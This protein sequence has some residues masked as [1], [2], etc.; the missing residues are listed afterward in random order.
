MTNFFKRSITG[1]LLAGMI[2]SMV[3]CGSTKT[4]TTTTSASTAAAAESTNTSAPVKEPVTLTLFGSETEK[5]FPTG[6]QTDAVAMDIKNKLG[7]TIDIVEQS[8]TPEKA[9]VLVASGDIPDMVQLIRANMEPLIT[10]K[11]LLPLD[12]LLKTNGPDIMKNTALAVAYSKKYMSLGQDKVY[13]LSSQV[14]PSGQIGNAIAPYIRWDYY[15]ELGYPAV[16]SYDDLLNVVDQMVKKHPTNENN[17]KQFGFSMWFD[18][19]TFA[20]GMLTGYQTAVQQI[21]PGLGIDQINKTEFSWIND[22]DAF[23]WKG[24][25][26]WNKANRMGLLDPDALTQSYDQALQKAGANRVICSIAKWVQGS[27]NKD[28]AKAGFP[29]RGI[30][31]LPP[32]TGTDGYMGGSKMMIGNVDRSWAISAECKYPDRAMDLLNYMFSEEGALT[33]YN[34]TKGENWT[35]NNGKYEM[36]QKFTDAIKNDSNYTLTSGA[37]KYNTWPGLGPTYQLASKQT[38][39][40]LKDK[41][42]LPATYTQ[43]DKD[44][45]KYYGIDTVEDIV[46]KFAK[47]PITDTYVDQ[48]TTKTPPTDINAGAQK[49][50]AYYIK[51]LPKMVLAKSDDQLNTMIAKFRADLKEMNVDA[52]QK[53][54][55]DDFNKAKSIEAEFLASVK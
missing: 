53:W 12:D 48:F 11:Q 32:F 9:K 55:I 50:R 21:D 35:E 16:N 52:I 43:V 37:N 40:F 26:F 45:C 29:E 14:D 31:P 22:D 2:M 27:T 49:I 47:Q 41:A 44:Y 18:W 24:V 25:R 46:F 36:T 10:N 4:D 34:G 38:I 33:M 39:H 1:V 3:A 6:V 23:M 8:S 7:I 15:A 28:L 5:T 17:Q 54:Y 13:C 42:M 20:F 30:E 51:E 19:D